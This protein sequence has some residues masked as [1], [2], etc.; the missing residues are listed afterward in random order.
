MRPLIM[1]TND[2]GVFSP[3]IRNAA[4]AAMRFGEVLIVAPI[5]QQSGM[6]RAFPRI[7]DQGIIERCYLNINGQQ[8]IAYGVHG[9]PANAAAE[10]VAEIAV[11]KPDLLISGINYGCNMGLSLTSSGTMGACFEVYSLGIPVLA[12]SLE[13]NMK[14]AMDRKGYANIDFS[15]AKETAEYWIDDMLV[16]RSGYDF[17]NVNVPYGQIN[18]EQYTWTFQEMQNY[19]ALLEEQKRTEGNDK[20]YILKYDIRVDPLKLHKGSDMF[21]VCEDRQI[22]VTPIT[23]DMTYREGCRRFGE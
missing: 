13:T 10:G 7:P 8:M 21:T 1:V 22:S 6:G 11:R 5:Q 16:S 18:P 20:P 15:S 2:D 17:L 23:M 9:S 12:V 19:Y 14:D 4:E 3:G